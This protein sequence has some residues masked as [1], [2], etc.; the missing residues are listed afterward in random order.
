MERNW[1]KLRNRAL[2][3]YRQGIKDFLGFALRTSIN[4]K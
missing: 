3:E 2:P 1:V 4:G